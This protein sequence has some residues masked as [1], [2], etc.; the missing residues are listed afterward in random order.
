[1]KILCLLSF[2]CLFT[3]CQAQSPF[4]TKYVF[5][6]TTDGFRWQE[7][8]TGADSLLINDP[9]VVE[10]TSLLKSQFWDADQYRRRKL[11]MPFFWNVMAKSG[12]LYG[13]RLLGNKMNVKN[14]YKISYPGYNEIFTGYADPRPNFN[15]AVYNRNE[16]ILGFLNNLPEHKGK[17]V[18]FSS[19]NM[20]P[21]ILNTPQNGISFNSGYTNMQEDEDTLFSEVNKTENVLVNKG[22]T[23]MDQLTFL[24]A[25]EYIKKNKPHV[26]FIGLGETDE[27]AHSR[28][29]DLYLQQ[30]NAVDKMISDLWYFIQ[31]NPYY[32]N[33]TTLLITTDHGRGKKQGTWNN[34]GFWISGSGQTWLGILGPDVQPLGELETDGNFYADQLAATI[35]WLLNTEYVNRKKTGERLEIPVIGETE[36]KS[37]AAS[38]EK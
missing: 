14:L 21:Y 28:R 37:T 3:L 13:N 30:A 6:V 18:A 7:L 15:H 12:I 35:G 27:F 38:F 11:L 26:A 34:H 25:M 17:V 9:S 23:R 8:F 24:N 5:I 36:R 16:N 1:M 10:D 20:F 32:R 22:H 29:Y 19:W 2:T 4:K 33:Q 31:S